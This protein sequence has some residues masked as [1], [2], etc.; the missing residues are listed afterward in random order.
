MG[1][2]MALVTFLLAAV[3]VAQDAPTN[4]IKATPAAEAQRATAH[5]TQDSS[6]LKTKKE[7]ISYA[8]GMDLGNQFRR[9]SIE[10]SPALFGQGLKD[11]LSGGKT[12]LSEEQVRAVISAIQGEQKRKEA[13]GRKGSDD[14]DVELK[15]LG[16]YNAK[17]GEAFLAA[18]KDKEGVVSLPS[19][20]QYKILREGNGPKPAPG[21]TV[22]CH[23]RA[24]LLDGTE[25]D[26]TYKRQEPKTLK[27]N[28]TIKAL[29]EALPLMPTGSKWEPFVPPGLA[30][31]ESGAGPIGPNATLKYEV[32]LL[33]IK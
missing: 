25:L 26:D 21:D 11:A 9:A 27:V 20:L 32:E 16:A 22:T 2:R 14:D 15:M 17:T 7:K 4:K 6:A 33:S 13:D 5:K 28:G 1:W 19:G 29:S 12:L 10:V 3:A 18:N 30:Y 23:V 31:G 24:A 8:L